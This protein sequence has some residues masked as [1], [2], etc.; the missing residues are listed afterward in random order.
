MELIQAKYEKALQYCKSKMNRKYFEFHFSYVPMNER[1]RELDRFIWEAKH[2][3]TRYK[4]RYLGDIVIDISEWSD[5]EPNEYF[6]AFLYY[7][8]DV[9][10]EQKCIFISE[11]VC[12][13]SITEKMQEHFEITIR[14]FDISPTISKKV[15]H[16]GFTDLTEEHEYV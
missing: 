10:N 3:C 13:K 12:E 6:H 2:Q 5:K 7:I 16:I 15:N 1:F 9:Y 8:K 4:N 11:R 14:T